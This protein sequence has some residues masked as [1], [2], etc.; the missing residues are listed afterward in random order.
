MFYYFLI[1]INK[2]QEKNVKICLIFRFVRFVV[3][4]LL[5]L[6]RRQ[7]TNKKNFF[8]SNLTLQSLKRKK[9]TAKVQ[10]SNC[11]FELRIVLSTALSTQPQAIKFLFF[12]FDLFAKKLK[13]KKS[14]PILSVNKFFILRLC[15]R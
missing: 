7:Q 12:L 4:F 9:I 1:S 5:K 6:E 14:F 13:K 10:E 11:E 15:F 2:F 3:I 8:F